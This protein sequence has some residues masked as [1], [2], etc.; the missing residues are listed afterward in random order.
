MS[1]DVID[2]VLANSDV[3]IKTKGPVETYRDTSRNTDD[4]PVV[5]LQGE[6]QGPSQGP[7]KDPKR[8]IQQGDQRT[9]RCSS[10]NKSTSQK[11]TFAHLIMATTIAADAQQIIKLNEQFE[12]LR[13]ANHQA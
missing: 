4:I 2:D 8:V 12:Q 11:V 1:D 7:K 5:E 13:G 10:A 3:N 9:Q 6:L